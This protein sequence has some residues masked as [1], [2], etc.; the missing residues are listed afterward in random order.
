MISFYTSDPLLMFFTYTRMFGIWLSFSPSVCASVDRCHLVNGLSLSLVFFLINIYATLGYF[1]FPSSF[2]SST[3]PRHFVSV[4]GTE[5]IN[6]GSTNHFHVWRLMSRV[7]WRWLLSPSHF[8]I[9]R[10]RIM[11]LPNWKRKNMTTRL[12]VRTIWLMIKRQGDLTNRY[13]IFFFTSRSTIVVRSP[14]SPGAFG[15]KCWLHC[16]NQ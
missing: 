14:L 2:P 3:N 4:D 16:V 9:V 7:D 15:L 8:P 1:I 11:P 5:R 6:V 13:P 10:T 12:I